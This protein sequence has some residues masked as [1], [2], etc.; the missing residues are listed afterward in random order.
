VV[1]TGAAPGS[2]APPP[3]RPS[4]A[5]PTSSAGSSAD[6]PGQPPATQPYVSGPLSTIDPLPS[7]SPGIGD[8]GIYDGQGRF[9]FLHGVNAVYK[10]S[11]YTL[12][13][14][15]GKPWN[16]DATDAAQ[17]AG[18]GFNV[19]RLGILW[20]GIEPGTVGPNNPRI[21]TKGAPGDP[22]QWNQ[23]VADA[24]IGRVEQ[25]V[26][27]L[28]RYHVYSLIDMHQDVY[29]QVFRGE[30]FPA[31]AV[32]TNG[33]PLKAL[34]GR[35]SN[36]Y[37]NRA[38]DA[39]FD[40][41]WSNDVVGDLQGEFDRSW[42]AVATALGAYPWVLGYDP[43]NEPFT[44]AL[45]SSSNTAVAT[46]LEC[47]YTGSANPGYA[48]SPNPSV[49]LGQRLDCGPD[50]PS[51]GVIPSIRDGDPDGMIFIEPTIYEYRQ[52]QNF[53]GPLPYP[54][55][56]L[57][58]HAYCGARSPVTG[59]PYNEVSC[60]S[61]V[62]RR[63]LHR[64]VEVAS[65]P[66]P[67]QPNGLPLFLSEFGATQNP[68]LVGEATDAANVLNVGWSYWSWKY[69]NDPTGSSKEALASANGH[70]NPQAAAL[71]QSYP[72]AVAGTVLIYLYEYTDGDLYLSYGVDPRVT[73]PTLIYISKHDR[74]FGYC[75]DIH[76]A[77]VIS[78]PGAPILEVQN[79]PTASKVVVAVHTAPGRTAQETDG[80]C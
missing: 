38:L 63:F 68:E 3:A 13:V 42:K 29:S 72:E 49:L 27:L 15:P 19:V 55:L 2:G 44:T 5:Q 25:V 24:Y 6:Q 60:F 56:V 62:E 69:Y 7:T 1:A 28:G 39:A 40:N 64:S 70:L 65:N 30:G 80:H 45:S 23:G 47:F 21:C 36:N 66:S 53:I 67:S 11:P 77:T 61:E 51:E 18:L 48:E 76:G 43:I 34:P 9:V 46:Q 73:A 10:R 75:V 79:L 54:N 58:F 26:D 59:T 74:A 78:A 8:A 14:A 52:N 20:Q 22:G 50:I 37:G 17:I 12:E 71:D 16:F 32:C 31:W 33:L 41:F 4:A 57:N 35:W